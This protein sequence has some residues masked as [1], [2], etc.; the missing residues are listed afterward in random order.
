MGVCYFGA[1]AFFGGL[2]VLLLLLLLGL[3]EYPVALVRL[4]HLF[5]LTATPFFSWKKGG[6][7]PLAPASGPFAALRGSLA[8]VALRGYRA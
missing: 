6:Q 1:L 2:L 7:K 4:S 3:G 5:A 8:P